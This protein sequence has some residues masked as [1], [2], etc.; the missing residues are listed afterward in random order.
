MVVGTENFFF[1]TQRS[2][3]ES[4]KLEARVTATKL[5]HMIDESGDENHGVDVLIRECP[6]RSIERSLTKLMRTTCAREA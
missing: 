6:Q 1:V 5:I 2:E 4:L 3:Q